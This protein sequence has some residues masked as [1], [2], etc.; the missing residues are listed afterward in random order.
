MKLL[1]ANGVSILCIIV[2]AVMAYNSIPYWGWFLV[3][4]VLF[5]HA[6]DCNC[7]EDE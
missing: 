7:N 4:A 2:A 5:G 1:L 6:G 3:I